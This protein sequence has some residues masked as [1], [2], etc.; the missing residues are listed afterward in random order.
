ML[1]GFLKKSVYSCSIFVNESLW[2]SSSVAFRDIAWKYCLY[3][4]VFIWPAILTFLLN[5][6]CLLIVLQ[7]VQ[8]IHQHVKVSYTQLLK[9]AI[10]FFSHLPIKVLL[11]LISSVIAVHVSVGAVLSRLEQHA[12]VLTWESK[13]TCSGV[14]KP[15]HLSTSHQTLVRSV[16]F[17]IFRMIKSQVTQRDYRTRR[18]TITCIT[19][20]WWTMLYQ[21][22]IVNRSWRFFHKLQGALL[23]RHD[24]IQSEHILLLYPIVSS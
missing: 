13:I 8:H 15:G 17:V 16:S 7:F 2:F 23:L 11:D 12:E 1:F 3:I 6:N 18:L 21:P 9:I 19:S 5:V 20:Y 14:E 22:T 10:I 4:I 24:L